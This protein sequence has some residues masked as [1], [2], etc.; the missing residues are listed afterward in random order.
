[1]KV[2]N[3]ESEPAQVKI[4]LEGS[5]TS[6]YKMSET[7]LSSASATDE[8]SLDFP[9][10]VAPK[11]VGNAIVNRNFTYLAKPLSLT[12]LRF[13]PEKPIQEAKR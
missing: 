10:K 2:V 7:W 4:A 11:T 8:N 1:M 6:R 12:I 13:T 9:N 3:S 5:N